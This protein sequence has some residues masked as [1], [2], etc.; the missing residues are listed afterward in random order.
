MILLENNVPL[1]SMEIAAKVRQVRFKTL[2]S[3]FEQHKSIKDQVIKMTSHEFHGVLTL[4]HFDFDCLFNTII[5]L[6]VKKVPKLPYKYSFLSGIHR[7][8]VDY[9]HKELVMQITFPCYDVNVYWSRAVRRL[10]SLCLWLVCDLN[11]AKINNISHFRQAAFSALYSYW[12]KDSRQVF[13]HTLQNPKL[14][15]RYYTFQYHTVEYCPGTVKSSLNK[16]NKI[17]E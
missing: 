11:G 5:R 4:R 15:Y 6:A 17:M 2:M 14:E 12:P 9:P 10:C 1:Y 16:Q 3:C 8:P 7:R 13:L